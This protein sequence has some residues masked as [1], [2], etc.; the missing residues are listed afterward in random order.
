MKT[1]SFA[2]LLMASMVFVLMA[3]SDKSSP[4]VSST[5]Q[6]LNSTSGPMSLGKMT[7][8][9]FTGREDMIDF[10]D[11]KYVGNGNR[12][13]GKDV[14]FESLWSASVPLLDGAVVDYTFNASFNGSGEGPMQGRF[15]MAVGGGTFEGTV[16]G[17]MFAVTED[18]NQ[19]IFKYVAQ[20]KGG[21]I[22]GM[23]LS[24]TETYYES[25]SFAFYRTVTSR[26]TSRHT[27]QMMSS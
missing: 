8:I 2:L 23:K 17:K 16:E 10:H 7:L 3:C 9:P 25:R 6:V 15:T 5:D 13:V 22:D 14:W 4:V 20:G 27:E 1:L 24:C 21:S 12:T 19:G 26:V 18:I 11:G